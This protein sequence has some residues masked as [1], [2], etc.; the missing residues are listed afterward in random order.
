MGRRGLCGTVGFQSSASADWRTVGGGP[1]MY[2]ILD[3]ARMHPT[4]IWLVRLLSGV[5]QGWVSRHPPPCF[6]FDRREPVGVR[7]REL[8]SCPERL[9]WPLDGPGYKSCRP[10]QRAG[11]PRE[12]AF[13]AACR[14]PKA[15]RGK[16]KALSLRPENHVSGGCAPDSTGPRNR[17]VQR[18]LSAQRRV[19]RALS[20]FRREA[21][22]RKRVF[23]YAFF[24]SSRARYSRI[25]STTR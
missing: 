21:E 5:K 22:A 8:P 15:G 1:E 13:C 18:R 23:R 17:A 16:R 9:G 12:R 10:P 11:K 3:T 7:E 4:S 19:P 20:S 6:S 14:G 24:R 25:A 2:P